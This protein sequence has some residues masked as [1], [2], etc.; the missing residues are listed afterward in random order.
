LACVI[1]E[2]A[3]WS[4]LG[5]RGLDDYYHQRVEAAG[6]VPTLSNTGYSGC[7]HDTTKVL[8]VVG[9]MHREVT[10]RCR[11][12]IDNVVG[13]V[14][15]IVSR[16]MVQDPA[17]RPDART[18]YDDL[19]KA[20]ELATPTTVPLVRDTTK[21]PPAPNKHTRRSVPANMSP[22]LTSGL[23][24][25]MDASSRPFPNEAHRHQSDN[26]PE[27]R[28][29]INGRPSPRPTSGMWSSEQD[30]TL[31]SEPYSPAA[32]TL[33]EWQRTALA[34]IHS[35]VPQPTTPVSRAAHPSV[36]ITQALEHVRL[37]QFR[38]PTTL[39]GEE[40]LNRLHGRDQV[41]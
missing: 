40:W 27:R 7:F 13:S 25:T 21:R 33:H 32:D 17:R 31:R 10:Q 4:V 29:T 23:G 37:K 1:S 12:A 26:L 18:V 2:A 11:A 9:E 16:M 15:L 35:H 41:F 14:L 39:S 5:Q 36:S 8:S 38:L 34:P 30:E 28:T 19:T 3:V 20:I 24:V 22:S 6:T